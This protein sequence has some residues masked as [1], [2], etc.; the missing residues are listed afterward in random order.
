M[1]Y[2]D[3]E[4]AVE[5][6]RVSDERLTIAANQQPEGTLWVHSDAQPYT[7]GFVTPGAKPALLAALLEDAGAVENV[8]KLSSD[9]LQAWPESIF[10]PLPEGARDLTDQNGNKFPIDCVSAAMG[11]HMA[12]ALRRALE[13]DGLFPIREEGKT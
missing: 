12:D 8:R 3:D 4:N 2:H 1:I 7:L 11:R 5:V 9:W 6:L 10:R 13:R